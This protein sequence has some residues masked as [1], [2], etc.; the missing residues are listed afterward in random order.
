MIRHK[1]KQ[2]LGFIINDWK[3][4][5]KG[6]LRIRGDDLVTFENIDIDINEHLVKVYKESK[7]NFQDVLIYQKQTA[8]TNRDNP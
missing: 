2:K 4:K 7:R 6:H 3:N 1:E 5:L 8:T